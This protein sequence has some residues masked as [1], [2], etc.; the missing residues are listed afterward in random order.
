MGS[1]DHL[2]YQWINLVRRW[3]ISDLLFMGK[4][5]RYLPNH[6]RQVFPFVALS[7]MPR[8]GGL[9]FKGCILNE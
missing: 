6:P 9:S 1:H 5:L 2:L 7:D 4:T 8:L 3:S